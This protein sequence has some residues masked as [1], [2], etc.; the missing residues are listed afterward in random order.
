MFLQIII[1]V[2]IDNS[3]DSIETEIIQPSET[4]LE[5]S[6]VKLHRTIRL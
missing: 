3:Q 2:T 1:A 4:N 6:K 5:N